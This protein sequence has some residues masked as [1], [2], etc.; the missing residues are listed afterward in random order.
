MIATQR[1]EEGLGTQPA[2]VLLIVSMDAPIID[3]KDR[4]FS[5]IETQDR[6]FFQPYPFQGSESEEL[7]EGCK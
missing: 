3:L 1:M 5:G 7:T 2:N 6:G 4:V